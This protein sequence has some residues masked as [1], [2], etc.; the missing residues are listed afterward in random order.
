MGGPTLSFELG[1]R[2]TITQR[3]PGLFAHSINAATRYCAVCG[4]PVRHSASPAMQNAGIAAL[5]LNWWYLALEVHPEHLRAAIK[6]AGAMG[7]IGLN[8][9]VPHKLLAMEIVDALDVTARTW[10]AVN[11]I[12]F[13]GR[14]A[15]GPWRPLREFENEPP[16]ETRSLGF[17]TDADGLMRSL[18][19]D[20]G[21]EPAG[22]KVL[23]LGAGG[24][25]RVA[26]LRLA[27]EGVAELF[28]VNRTRS[29]AEEIER[30]VRAQSPRVKVSL[31]YPGHEVDLLLNGTSLGLRSDDASPVDEALFPLRRARAVYDMIYRP[32]ET[33]L[34]Q[35]ARA[36]GCR[37]ANGLGMLLHQGALA[38][39]IWSGRP[40]P[41]AEM[42]RALEEN[43]RSS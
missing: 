40:A 24:A 14:V 4:F 8:L 37:S 10:G 27:M 17:N 18:R 26:A 36:A 23:L 13:E 34:L 39:E 38:L 43:V 41:V 22:A 35:R 1:R 15:S 42:R 19:A 30:A 6:G 33:P 32:A 29:R 25:G 11:T 5:D 12:R 31:S 21:F 20:L 28:V 16:A 9:T 3:V 2:A 7:F